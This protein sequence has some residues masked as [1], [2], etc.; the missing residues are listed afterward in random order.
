MSNCLQEFLLGITAVIEKVGLLSYFLFLARTTVRIRL[1]LTAVESWM[2]ETAF[3]VKIYIS[4][5]QN[6]ISIKEESQFF[7]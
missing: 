2:L 1:N 7:I 4:V 5:I 6:E 3:E